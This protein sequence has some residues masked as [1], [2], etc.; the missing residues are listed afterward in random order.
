MQQSIWGKQEI[1]KTDNKTEIN[2]TKKA[3][4]PKSDKAVGNITKKSP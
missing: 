3:C 1:N 4:N 2:T